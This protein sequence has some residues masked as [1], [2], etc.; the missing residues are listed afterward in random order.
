MEIREDDLSGPE[1]IALLREHLDNMHAIT[2]PGSVH[3]MPVEQLRV[4]GVTFW[5]AWDAYVLLGCG[6]LKELDPNAGE[7][8]S[9]RTCAAARRK[10]VAR[11]L[12]EHIVNEACGREYQALYLETGAF[13]E[14]E[15]AR[16]LYASRGF[17]FCGPFGDYA[18]D[19]NSVFMRLDLNP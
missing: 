14:F 18:N 4:P 13:P 7:I 19:P 12:L 10:G 8:K 11:R 15:P 16:S 17:E 5:S 9:M 3:A 1:I 2:P 6:A